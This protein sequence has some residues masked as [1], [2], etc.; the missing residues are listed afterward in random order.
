MTWFV[1]I[2]KGIVSKEIFDQFVPLHI[3]YVKSL[4]DLGHQATTG[5][6]GEL[7]GG[8]LLFQAESFTD[9]QNIVE[10]DPFVKNNCVEYQLHEWCVV[11]GNL[12]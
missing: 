10:N 5:Y 1:K 2:E 8:M 3:E 6:W 11:A 9:A 7:G 4:N 12:L